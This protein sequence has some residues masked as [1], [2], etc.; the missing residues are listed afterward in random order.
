MKKFLLLMFL[1]LILSS[2]S[3]FNSI[4]ILF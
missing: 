2:C 4:N 3:E 1:V